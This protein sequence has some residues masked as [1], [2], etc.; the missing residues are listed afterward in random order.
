MTHA[1]LRLGIEPPFQPLPLGSGHYVAAL[2]NT[3]G[4]LDALRQTANDTWSKF[5]PLIQIVGPKSPAKQIKAGNITAWTGKIL[6]A[7]G[8]HPMFLDILRPHASHP[9][10]NGKGE[11]MPLLES[12]YRSARKRTLKFVPVFRVGETNRAH[13]AM[14]IDAAQE[15]GRGIALRWAVRSVTVPSG[16]TVADYLGKLLTDLC[17][18]V[19]RTDLLLDLGYIDQD[20]EIH[21]DDLGPI[22]SKALEVGDWRNVVLMGTS[23][24]SM[25]GCVKEGTVGEIERREWTTWT[26]ICKFGLSRRPAFGDYAIQS[27]IPPNDVTGGGGIG[28]ANIRYTTTAS[29]A[30]ARGRGPWNQ[31]GLEQYVGLCQKLLALREF[32]GARYTWGDG[33]IDGCARGDVDPESQRMWRG[34]GTS[35]HLRFVTDQLASSGAA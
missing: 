19:S 2:Q 17:S 25:L 1:Q 22:V 24:P 6:H 16:M 3:P 29:T 30:V 8:E 32:S 7:V 21:P 27:P 18:E 5:T 26:E 9:V 4:E 35:H 10:V 28:R 33:I 31:D 15:D 13:A 23:I 20:T 11:E 12:I 34:A 14:V